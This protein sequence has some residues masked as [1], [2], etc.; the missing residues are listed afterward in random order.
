MIVTAPLARFVTPVVGAHGRK[1][2]LKQTDAGAVVIGGAF[3]GP[4]RDEADCRAA[5]GDL[6]PARIGAS[7]GNA[8]RDLPASRAG[9]DP[10]RLDRA[11]GH[12]ARRLAGPRAQPACPGLVHAFGFSAHGFALAPLVGRM[13][14]DHLH[15]GTGA[16]DMA[17]FSP[18]RFAAPAPR[19]KELSDA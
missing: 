5:R 6:D 15:H 13:V 19:R 7:L 4:L 12:D 3:E 16:A 9:P 10:A 14:A 2:S 17:P 8:V 1:L 18:A 11:G